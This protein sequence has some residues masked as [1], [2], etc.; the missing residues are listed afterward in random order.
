MRPKTMQSYWKG[1]KDPATRRLIEYL[2]DILFICLLL[3][4]RHNFFLLVSSWDIW[5][6]TGYV[7][8]DRNN[9]N[10]SLI[11]IKMLHINASGRF[12]S[13]I[14]RYFI[15]NDTVHVHTCPI[16][17]CKIKCQVQNEWTRAAFF[18]FFFFLCIFGSVYSRSRCVTALCRSKAASVTHSVFWHFSGN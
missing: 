13:D 10:E 11:R 6:T 12:W 8:T 9:Q 18:F 2:S 4:I 5:N 15:P 14:E 7:H 1:E 17:S 16:R 3:K